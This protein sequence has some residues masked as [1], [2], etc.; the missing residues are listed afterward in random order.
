MAMPRRIKVEFGEVFPYG[1]FA[2]SE[3][4]ALRD[5]DRST[6]E[7]PVQ[8]V[9]EDTGL[10]VWVVDVVDA[11]PEA[12]KT[13]VLVVTRPV[14]ALAVFDVLGALAA[15]RPVDIRPVAVVADPRR[16]AWPVHLSPV[17][18]VGNGHHRA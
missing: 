3:V 1:V 16:P 4:T 6:A 15:A 9:D 17:V 13:L 11:D 5:F 10:L 14:S 7:R 18:E 8:A 12:R 2:V